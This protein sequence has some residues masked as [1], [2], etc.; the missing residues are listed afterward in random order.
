MNQQV[1]NYYNCIIHLV[2]IAEKEGSV[3]FS[4]NH[5]MCVVDR[6]KIVLTMRK[7]HLQFMLRDWTVNLEEKLF[8]SELVRGVSQLTSFVCLKVCAS[9]KEGY[10]LNILLG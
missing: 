7:L 2:L 6:A 1:P 10:C 3:Y 5:S 4:F 8:R 9:L